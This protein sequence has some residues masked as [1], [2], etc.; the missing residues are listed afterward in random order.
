[1]AVKDMLGH[2]DLA[3]TQIYTHVSIEKLKN[4]YNKAHPHGEK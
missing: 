2:K 4:A 3:S 1:M